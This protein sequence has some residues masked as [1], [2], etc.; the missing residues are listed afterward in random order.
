MQKFPSMQRVNTSLMNQ[1]NP[2]N[3]YMKILKS[4]I[5]FFSDLK[6]IRFILIHLH[7]TVIKQGFS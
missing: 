1:Q 5:S 3:E 6:L 4:K 7:F 2:S